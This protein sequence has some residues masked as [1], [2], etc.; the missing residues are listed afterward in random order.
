M[1][2]GR[3]ALFLFMALCISMFAQAKSVYSL[4]YQQALYQCTCLQS[5][6]AV[7]LSNSCEAISFEELDPQGKHSWLALDADLAAVEKHQPLGLFIFGKVAS[8]AY[9]N[10]QLL[11]ENGQP[12][13]SKAQ[14]VVGDM[15]SVFH[16]PESLIQQGNNRIVFELSSHHGF[17]ELMR[18]V[19]FIGVGQF[20]K[21]QQLV[22]QNSGIGLVLLGVLILGVLY[23]VT[24][25]LNPLQRKAGGFL[26][27]MALFASLQL[28]AELSRGLFAYAY[29]WH[30]IRLLLITTLAVGFGICLLVFTTFKFANQHKWHWIYGG[31]LLTLV[32][33]LLVP[34]FDAKTT[35]GI[36]IP[37]LTAK[38][39]VG[40]EAARSKNS[41]L[42][43]YF[44]VFMS[45]LVTLVATVSYFHEFW[46]YLLLAVL[47]SYLLVQQTREYAQEQTLR[48]QEQKQI[49][50]LEYQ[51]EQAN[52]EGS[53]NTIKIN[54]SGK[55]E[56]I[57]TNDIIYCQASGDYVE[58]YLASRSLLYSGSLKT[59]TELLPATFIKVH[60]SY[61]VNLTK[62]TTMQ[63]ESSG[64]VLILTNGCQVP[65]SRR[66]MPEVRNRVHEV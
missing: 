62:V 24:L 26:L 46:F 63:S 15:D 1:T 5:S 64:G 54:S 61:L 20:Q 66:L 42:W 27:L 45:F 34:G 55:V 3:I 60:R 7:N 9:V 51:L 44:F 41:Q 33:V 6:L 48:Q 30:D 4:T 2:V 39:L 16:L 58:V 57:K 10:G 52:R 43:R 65:V 38:I 35:L 22:Q 13:A 19:H 32:A 47:L 36:F 37:C 31:T 18:P 29:P 11:G 49:A 59:I 12:G 25:S 50:K 8:R 40:V 56:V 53:L 14:E 17:I 23:F 28:F 21:P